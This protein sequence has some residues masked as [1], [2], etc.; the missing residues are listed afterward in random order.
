MILPRGEAAYAEGEVE[1]HGSGGY[2]LHVLHG[3][4]AEARDGALAEILVDAA[5]RREEGL[6]LFGCVVETA[7][8]KFGGFLFSHI[9]ILFVASR[10]GRGAAVYD[11]VLRCKVTI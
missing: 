1:T 9:L 3:V 5:Q 7:C 10:A 4:V 8:L 2:H 6:L 11:S